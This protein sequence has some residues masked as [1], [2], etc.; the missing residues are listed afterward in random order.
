MKTEMLQRSLGRVALAAIALGLL[1]LSGCLEQV[2]VWS[3]D[4]KRAAV[5]N[6]KND[7]LMLCDAD[8]NLSPLLVPDV[9]RVAW[10][11]DSQRLVLA[12]KHDE[13]KWAP[14]ARAMGRE[15]AAKV[16]TEAE[17]A[18]K[19]LHAGTPW[20]GV[21]SVAG[22]FPDNGPDWSLVCIYMREH[23]G[24]ALHS[25]LD[26]PQWNGVAQQ[27]VEIQEL[28]MARIEGDTI[29]TGTQLCEGIDAISDFRVSPGDRAVAFVAEM[30]QGKSKNARLWV[31]PVDASTPQLV[32]EQVAA[33]PDWTAD[34]RS[35]VYVQAS[36]VSF[37]D[38]LRLGTLV[39][40]EVLDADGGIKPQPEP[41]SLAGLMFSEQTRIRCLRDGRILFNAAE[42]SLPVAAEDFGD[43][44][45]QLFAIDPARQ[46]TLVRMIPR[47]QQENLPKSLTFFEVSPDQ[48][49]V[50]VGDINGSIGLLTLATGQAQ[51]IQEG[52]KES[53]Q[54]APAWRRDGEFT[55][56][57][58]TPAKDGEKPAR[59][60][61][62]VLRNGAKETVLSQS[63][64]DEMV[65][66]LFSEQ[67]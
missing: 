17:N 25:K 45:E 12:R 16:V 56:T 3:P 55:Y 60:V 50:L 36:G 6:A 19:K 53:L 32:A 24:E 47:G 57:R 2:C 34:G 65:N 51:Q 43:P 8:G 59:A 30:E 38:D 40:R 67:K 35:L 41:T 37:N 9:F 48:R 4:G 7:G 54:G 44:Q 61:E 1:L 23:Y 5:V 63:W 33:Y 15:R 52:T 39:Q 58:R 10:L 62:V 66:S 11:S 22:L 20:A 21:G 18:W 64:P 49:Q 14:I 28:L 26:E 29:V 46:A 31:V 42:F 27:S 13:V